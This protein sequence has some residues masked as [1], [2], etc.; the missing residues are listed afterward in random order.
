MI[1]THNDIE[2]IVG[3]PISDACKNLINKLDLT[4][5]P[6][7]PQERDAALLDIVRC[8][9]VNLEKTGQHRLEKWEKGWY[10]NFE[11]FKNGSSI[12]SL[13][14]KYFGKYNIARWKGEL[15]YGNTKYF[16]YYQLIVLI[17]A[18]LVKF[19]L[20]ANAKVPLFVERKVGCAFAQVLPPVVEYR[21]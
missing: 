1:I 13:V 8:L 16:D 18:I 2:E 17:D 6:L 21:A 5:E 3:F 12:D 15:V 14:P 11:L 20:W 4:F 9:N 10:E 7:T 19:P